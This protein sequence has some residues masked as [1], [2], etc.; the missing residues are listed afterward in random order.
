MGVASG[1]F[2]TGMGYRGLRASWPNQGGAR[3]Q[4]SPALPELNRTSTPW[5]TSGEFSTTTRLY[6]TA[7]VRA[8]SEAI[9][10]AALQASLGGESPTPT[11]AN[12]PPHVPD[13]LAGPFPGNM[14]EAA[15]PRISRQELAVASTDPQSVARLTSTQFSELFPTG[16]FYPCTDEGYS[17]LTTERFVE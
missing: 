12:H 8:G 4:A 9:D 11:A 2:G 5:S 1:T 7:H 6:P 3:E 14:P 13:S 15:F 10:T 16:P 17:C